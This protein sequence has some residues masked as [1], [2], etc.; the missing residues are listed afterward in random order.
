VKVATTPP[1]RV[2]RDGLVPV[3]PGLGA[4]VGVNVKVSLNVVIVC[5]EVKEVGTGNVFGPQMTWPA[6]IVTTVPSGKV[7]VVGS[8]GVTVM[9]APGGGAMVEV[10][11]FVMVPST[12]VIVVTTGPGLPGAPPGTPMVEVTVLPSGFVIVVTG[13]GSPVPGSTGRGGRVP[14]SPGD[15][16]QVPSGW[17]VLPK[18]QHPSKPACRSK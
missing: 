17:Q 11:M 5:G 2:V 14:G 13:A 7:D 9:G 1:G 6:E 10:I 3:G 18:L 8:G 12:F 15:A 4:A 16:R